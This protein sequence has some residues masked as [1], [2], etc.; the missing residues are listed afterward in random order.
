[1]GRLDGK[2]ALVSGSAMGQGEA[3]VRAFVAEGA[4]VVVSD[5]EDDA[6]KAVAES[7]GDAA[8]FEHL[9]VADDDDWARVVDA[10][11]DHWGKLD[12]LVNNAGF[13]VRGTAENVTLDDWHRAIAVMQTGPML[14]MRA[15]VPAMKA[16]GGGSIINTSSAAGLRGITDGMPYSAAKFALRG[17]TKSAALDLAVYGIRVN[18]VHPGL[19]DTP[20]FDR[21][22]PQRPEGFGRRSSLAGRPAVAE[23]IAPLVVYLASDESAFCSGAEFVVDS[24]STA[25]M[26]TAQ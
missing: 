2:V 24:G 26:W 14:G 19:V 12:V 17:M 6:G 21:F 7:L 11:V 9:D 16:A 23:D 13:M 20:F 18:S 8:I 1:M 25:G 10:V 3:H 15:V 22:M 5:V 4:R